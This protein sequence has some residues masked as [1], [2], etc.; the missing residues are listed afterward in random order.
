MEIERRA[1]TGSAD[2]EQASD[3]S[4]ENRAAQG[5][6]RRP[7]ESP[8]LRHL[9]SVRRLTLGDTGNQGDTAGTF[10]KGNMMMMG[11]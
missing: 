5:P 11:G 9:G 2:F 8:Q 6:V 3:A 1:S 4:G 10:Q 7:Y